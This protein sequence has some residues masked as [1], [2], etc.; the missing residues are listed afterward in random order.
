MV[1]ILWS[2]CWNWTTTLPSCMSS[3]HRQRTTQRGFYQVLAELTDS[4]VQLVRGWLAKAN[5]LW[6]EFCLATFYRIITIQPRPRPSYGQTTKHYTKQTEQSH[7]HGLDDDGGRPIEYS[8]LISSLSWRNILRLLLPLVLDDRA[9]S[10]N[11]YQ[12]FRLP[13]Y[14]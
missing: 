10:V 11:Q 6:G 3:L 13:G 5:T 1:K 14:M 2:F 7:P 8:T 4:V 9:D 12:F